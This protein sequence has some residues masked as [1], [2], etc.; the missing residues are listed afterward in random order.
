MPSVAH[1]VTTGNFAGV[2]R[3][4]CNAATELAARSWD[5]TVVGGHPER[6]PLALGEGIRW[7]PGATCAKAL[8]SLARLAEQDLCHAHMTIAEALAVAA[9][10][11][12]RAPIVST[13]HFAARRGSS[14]GG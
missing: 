13:R 4:V 8:R 7:L 1:V 6:M 14:R 3:Y 11:F 9:Q 12:H 10:P 2:E 5:V